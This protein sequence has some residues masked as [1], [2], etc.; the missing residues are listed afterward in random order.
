MWLQW[1]ADAGHTA[2]QVTAIAHSLIVILGSDRDYLEMLREF[3][4]EEDYEVLTLK[5]HADRAIRAQLILHARYLSTQCS[6]A[7]LRKWLTQLSYYE[8]LLLLRWMV[9][10]RNDWR[11]APIDLDS[12]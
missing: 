4:R 8:R 3:L 11:T 2:A 9:H 5:E 1:H 12:P 6:R 7:T 10:H